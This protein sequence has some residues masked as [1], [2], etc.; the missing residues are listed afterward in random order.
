MKSRENQQLQLETKPN[1]RTAGNL[2]KPPNGEVKS[3]KSSQGL[4]LRF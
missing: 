3:S 4:A 2:V 1:N